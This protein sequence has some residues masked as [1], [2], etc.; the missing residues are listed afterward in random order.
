MIWI[1]NLSIYLIFFSFNIN[2]SSS[3]ISEVSAKP[4]QQFCN[5]QYRYLNTVVNLVVVFK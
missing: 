5:R 3:S 4:L 2:S 1:T